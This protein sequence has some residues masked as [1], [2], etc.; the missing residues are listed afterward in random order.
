MNQG[1]ERIWNVLSWNVRGINSPSKWN[2]IRDKITETACDIV[3]F[4]ETKKETLDLAFLKNICPSWI[5]AFEFL[6]S[7]GASGG[8]LVAWKSSLFKGELVF[9]NEYAI[10]VEFNSQHNDS[11]WLLTNV[12]APCQAEDKLAFLEWLKSIQ[13]PDNMDWLIL[14]DFNL[15]RRPENRNKEGGNIMEMF[16]F[17]EAIS[18]LGL[19]EITLQ[20]R[21]Y[22]WS[23]KQASPLLE[24]LDWAFT[25]NSWLLSYLDTSLSALD[26][27]PSDHC[28]CVVKISSHIPKSAI[29]RF[30]NYCQY[31]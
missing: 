17:N 30:E 10:S 11:C 14:G 12:Y 27:T 7:I 15:I 29:F 18:A 1:H 21:K 16:L 28:P 24:K 20:G 4:Q 23:N 9:S 31:C 6:P 26:M 22:T 25:S 2:V 19:N 8:L 5:D 13:M 3:Y